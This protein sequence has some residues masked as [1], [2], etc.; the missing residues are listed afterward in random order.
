[1]NTLNPNSNFIKEVWL[2][3]PFYRGEK[4]GMET[5]SDLLKV[6][7][8]VGGRAGIQSQTVCLQSL[9]S[10]HVLLLPSVSATGKSCED[11]HIQATF[12]KGWALPG[13]ICGG[14]QN[15]LPKCICCRTY[16]CTT[17]TCSGLWALPRS[18]LHLLFT[19][20]HLLNF[21]SLS[22]HIHMV[23]V[24]GIIQVGVQMPTS[25]IPLSCG[26]TVSWW[27]G[28]AW[29]AMMLAWSWPLNGCLLVLS[30]LSPAPLPAEV[31]AAPAR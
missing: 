30:L 13:S 11:C 28:V 25:F 27:G 22:G 10:S 12:W 15:L 7:E 20:E 23:S 3:S 31:P 21:R 17:T 16:M 26:S 5:L 6:P 19:W 1:M 18:Y 29:P 2:S 8:L 9:C 4:W 14:F 24:L